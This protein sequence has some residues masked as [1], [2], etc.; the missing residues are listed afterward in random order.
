MDHAGDVRETPGVA[1]HLL[2]V[3]K[4][5][6]R[7]IVATFREVHR[8]DLYKRLALYTRDDWGRSYEWL[9]TSGLELYFLE[10]LKTLGIERA[11]PQEV[12]AGMERNFADNKVRTTKILEEFVRINQA[13]QREQ[14]SYC[15]VK[16][17]ALAP[18]S[19]PDPVLRRQLNM[20]FILSASDSGRCEDILAELGYSAHLL[21]KHY[22]EFHAK[23]AAQ[24]PDTGI[25][26]VTPPSIGVYF[27]LA[28]AQGVDRA[29]YAML[30]RRRTKTWDGHKFPA[31]AEPDHFIAQ[32]IRMLGQVGTE[33][34]RLAFLLEFR[35]CVH[36]WLHDERFWR[37]VIDRAQEHPLRPVAIATATRLA[38]EI[39]GGNIPLPLQKWTVDE[40]D[41][42]VRRWSEVYGWDAILTDFPD[43]TLG[44]ILQNPPR[45]S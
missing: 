12:R 2:S 8:D 5:L 45:N 35:T 6:A 24:P 7:A 16:G 43:T 26:T 18:I 44:D 23:P 38:A 25:K 21:G 14:L 39:F 17:I 37:E 40:L 19:C 31:P 30:E 3:N 27:V 15:N 42:G 36:F 34:T 33:W 29:P 41:A 4:D 28:D 20:D 10:R 11:V 13:L 9:D 22:S 1:G 32:A